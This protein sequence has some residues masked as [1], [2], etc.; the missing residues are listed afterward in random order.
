MRLFFLLLLVSSLSYAQKP[1]TLD[2]KIRDFELYVENARK[3]WDV[4]GLAVAVVKD[5]KIIL[6]KG[7]GVR[8][9]GKPD[10]VTPETLFACASTTKAMTAT[11]MGML[12]DE[13][14]VKWDDPVINYLPELQLYDPSATREIRI[15]DLFTHNTGVGNADFLWVTMN[16]SSDEVLKRMRDVKPSYSLRSSFIYQNIFYLA[17]GKVIEKVS[18]KTWDKFIRERIFQPLKMTNTV[19]FL[20]EASASNRTAPHY[21]IEDRIAVI[22]HTSADQ[23]GPAGSVWSSIDDMSKWMACMLDSSKYQ[24]GRL[25]KPATWTEMFKPQ[26]LVTP[27]EFYPTAQLTKPN[28]TT[29]GLGWFQHDYKGKKVNFHTGSLAGAVAIHAQLPDQNLGIYVFG[30]YDHAE[31]RHALVYKSF[32]LFA[33]GG[34]R[35]W[36]SEFKT[37][38]DKLNAKSEKSYKD[39]EANRVMNT[40]PTL[41]IESYAGKYTNPVYGFVEITANGNQLT[42]NVNNFSS[43]TLDHWNYDTFR[44]WFSKK[45]YGKTN[46]VFSLGANG[47]VASVNFRGVDFRKAEEPAAKPVGN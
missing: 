35:D 7:F 23:I 42:A 30:N 31:V 15:R 5:G 41:P 37:L 36:S 14:K 24:G 39:F 32:D 47:K 25:L 44:G 8:E 27:A 11:C 29:Y 12:V 40:N 38:Y 2:Q 20:K 3:Q 26:V 4:P 9:L 21:K 22:E 17:A 16:I 13:G 6:S 1:V 33:L 18:G 19:P 43:A 45:W 10:P 34:A 28:W 46:A